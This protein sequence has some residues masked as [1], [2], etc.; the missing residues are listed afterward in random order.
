[1]VEADREGKSPAELSLDELSVLTR[2][3]KRT[4]RYY[5]QLGLLE[6]PIGVTRAA[7]YGEQHLNRLMQI[8]QLSAAGF[9]LDRIRIAA[10]EGEQGHP[11]PPGAIIQRTQLVLGPGVDLRINPAHAE[12]S[13][14]QVRRLFRETL[15]SYCGLI[16]DGPRRDET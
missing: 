12:L 4:V 8:K 14:A 16:G 13:P 1:M 7:R 5:I 9:S 10:T 6:R 3:A 2:T 11:R 15:A